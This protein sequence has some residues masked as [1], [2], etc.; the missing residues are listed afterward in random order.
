M[1]EVVEQP[2]VKWVVVQRGSW[3]TWS[4]KPVWMRHSDTGTRRHQTTF[5]SCGTALNSAVKRSH[6][7]YCSSN[8]YGHATWACMMYILKDFCELIQLT[9][10]IRGSRGVKW[11]QWCHGNKSNDLKSSCFSAFLSGRPATS[12]Q[13]YW[14]WI[15]QLI[16][17][18]WSG[19]TRG[20][21]N[22]KLSSF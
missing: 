1:T 7:L 3:N 11:L 20:H 19:K 15:R 18:L 2:G 8:A 22:I 17:K 5:V 4:G 13:E 12:S 6:L 14:L 10:L 16:R 9:M 21:D